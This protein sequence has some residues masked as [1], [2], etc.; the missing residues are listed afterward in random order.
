MMIKEYLQKEICNDLKRQFGNINEYKE[1]DIKS[2]IN[3]YIKKYPLLP[4]SEIYSIF[5]EILEHKY[6]LKYF[7]VQK[8]SSGQW[9]K[10]SAKTRHSLFKQFLEYFQGDSLCGSAILVEADSVDDFP[11]DRDLFPYLKREFAQYLY[12]IR[13]EEFRYAEFIKLKGEMALH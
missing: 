9:Q 13:R 3:K 2:Y 6:I 12:Y 1:I 5:M 11:F 8:D 7:L 10:V 4:Y